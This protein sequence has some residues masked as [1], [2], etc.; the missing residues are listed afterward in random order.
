[1][2]EDDFDIIWFPKYIGDFTS[3]T[4]HLSTEQIGAYELLL[5]AYYRRKGLLPD[6]DIKLAA[7]TKLSVSRWLK[8]R[9]TMEE[10]FSVSGGFWHHRRADSEIQKIL[11]QHKLAVKRGKAGMKSRYGKPS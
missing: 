7:I 11:E 9:P 4:T 3:A 5:M 2:S 6:D 8:H 10:F 1:M